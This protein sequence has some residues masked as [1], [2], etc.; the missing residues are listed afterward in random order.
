MKFSF[1]GFVSGSEVDYYFRHDGNFGFSQ[2]STGQASLH[3]PQIYQNN[4]GAYVKDDIYKKQKPLEV[5][6]ILKVK[7]FRKRKQR[8]EDWEK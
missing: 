3:L 5:E 7:G 8:K 6:V 4:D 2:I 1:K